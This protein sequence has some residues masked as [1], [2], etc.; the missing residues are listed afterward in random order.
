MYTRFTGFKIHSH[1]TECLQ[2]SRDE[3]TPKLY[4]STNNMDPAGFRLAHVLH[5]GIEVSILYDI[6]LYVDHSIGGCELT[7][8]CCVY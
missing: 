8:Q 3:H 4:S 5:S 7:Y 6:I 1:S 2:C